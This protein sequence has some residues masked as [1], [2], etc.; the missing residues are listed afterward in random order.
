MYESHSSKIYIQVRGARGHGRR[1][2][3]R[4]H[5]RTCQTGDVAWVFV[6]DRNQLKPSPTSA[7]CKS[8]KQGA[9]LVI[10]PSALSLPTQSPAIKSLRATE[11]TT[12]PKVA[13]IYE[14]VP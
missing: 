4:A 8:G 14:M 7:A 11:A 10:P 6:P 13:G 3:T 5:D 9:D 12:A 2:G 1:H